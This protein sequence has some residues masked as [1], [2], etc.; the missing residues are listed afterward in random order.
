MVIRCSCPMFLG[1]RL[2]D[3]RYDGAT[4]ATLWVQRYTGP[5]IK[6]DTPESIALDPS[7]GS[8]F[9]V[10]PAQ[11]T[12]S[13]PRPGG[14]FDHTPRALARRPFW[15]QEH[16]IS[17]IVQVGLPQDVLDV[18]CG[19]RARDVKGLADLVVGENALPDHDENLEFTRRERGLPPGDLRG[20]SIGQRVD[21]RLGSP[22]DRPVSEPQHDGQGRD[23]DDGGSQRGQGPRSM[24]HQPDDT[25]SSRVVTWSKCWSDVA[26]SRTQAAEAAALATLN[27]PRGP[28]HAVAASRPARPIRRR[29]ATA[30][31]T[32][33]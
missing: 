13:C 2:R 23:D 3:D 8:A 33:M 32:M 14:R 15:A 25:S 18:R 6:Q 26:P 4:G 12:R 21:D 11:D 24:S 31:M 5:D 27:G 10:S 28:C 20:Q 19:G 29:V 30:S 16:E 22:E 1:R 9:H 17:S 7:G